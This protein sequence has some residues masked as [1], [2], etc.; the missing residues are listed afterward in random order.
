MSQLD[1]GRASV[2]WYLSTNK[3]RA[4]LSKFKNESFFLAHSTEEYEIETEV[5]DK[6]LRPTWFKKHTI[7][8]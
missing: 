3:Y 6:R 7:T 1:C 5:N 4:L 2:K 8:D